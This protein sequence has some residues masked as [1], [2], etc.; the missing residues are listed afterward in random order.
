MRTL[1]LTGLAVALTGLTAAAQA[2]PAQPPVPCRDTADVQFVCGL[3][4]PE[5]LVV[6]PGGQWVIGGAFSGS[7]GVYLIRT[8]DRTSAV[9][10]PSTRA[11]ERLDAKTY[12][13]CPGAPDAA[14]KAKFQTHGL[15]LRAGSNSVHTLFVV[16]HG[17]RESIEVFEVDARPQTPVLT[18]IGCAVAP[19]PIGLN[20]VRWL[21]EGGFIA[22]DFL[23]RGGAPDAMQKMQAGEKN[24]ALWEW[25]T[26]SGW[27]KVPGT[28]A[29]G[30]NGIEISED[31]QTLYVAAWGS[32]SFFRMGRAQGA[33]RD[34]IPLGFRVDNIRWAR[35]GSLLAAGQDM[36]A[37]AATVVARIDPKTLGVREVL[38]RANTPA[39]SN[40]TVAVEIGDKYWVGTFRGDRVAIFP[41]RPTPK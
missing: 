36:G 26:A 34:E 12:P 16:L 19:D 8:S 17:G 28:D 20:S 23:A 27:K 3:Q 10:Y 37:Q 31:G 14:T 4:S 9:A 22:T 39:F 18:W 21:P 40:G 13:S 5:D 41:A 29:A 25:H 38:R 24:G 1:I 32:Q 35:D 6:L 15:S 11:N 30:A 7:G 33:R 2:P